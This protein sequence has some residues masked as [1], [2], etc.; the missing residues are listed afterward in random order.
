MDG[1]EQRG[2]RRQNV[3]T[4]GTRA[5]LWWRRWVVGRCFEKLSIKKVNFVHIDSILLIAMFH[6]SVS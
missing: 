2:H 3:G 5:W 6:C 4:A 1:G